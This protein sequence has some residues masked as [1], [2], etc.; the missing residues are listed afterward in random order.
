LVHL[1]LKRRFI[2]KIYEE[3]ILYLQGV[4]MNN[5]SMQSSSV[6]QCNPSME[7]RLKLDINTKLQISM[8]D[9]DAKL[10]SEFVGMANDRCLIASLPDEEIPETL[11]EK[12]TVGNPMVIRYLHEGKIFG[13]ESA[14]L[15]SITKPVSLLFLSYPEN[16]EKIDLRCQERLSCLLPAKLKIDYR[17]ISGTIVDISRTG[18][19][20]K[21]KVEKVFDEKILFEHEKIELEFLLPGIED[22]HIITVSVKNYAKREKFAFMGILFKE[23]KEKTKKYLDAFI[24][25]HVSYEV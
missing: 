11:R 8:K 15:G 4:Y 17:A 20:F 13:F 24:E 23:V 25:R 2:Y 7:N 12:L 9:S 16:I 5:T 6:L 21:T 10:N 18:C 19:R 1:I 3:T 14:L 22:S